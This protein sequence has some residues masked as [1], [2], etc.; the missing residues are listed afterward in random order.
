V[1]RSATAYATSEAGTE[2]PCVKFYLVCLDVAGPRPVR[3]DDRDF[4]YEEMP[5]QRVL[6]RFRPGGDPAPST[7]TTSTSSTTTTSTSSTT[8]TSTSS[9]T[10]TS[11]STTTTT[12]T[13]PFK[14]PTEGIGLFP[15]DEATTDPR[16]KNKKRK[17]KRRDPKDA[18]DAAT[19]GGSA[20][21]G[22]DEDELGEE[23]IPED[24]TDGLGLFPEEPDPNAIA[25]AAAAAPK[26]D[27]LPPGIENWLRDNPDVPLRYPEVPPMLTQ[28]GEQ[29]WAV[30]LP[31]VVDGPDPRNHQCRSVK[32]WSHADKKFAEYYE[33]ADNVLDSERGRRLVF[34]N[35]KYDGTAETP[36]I[37]KVFVVYCCP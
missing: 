12:T 5:S 26:P 37:D 11:T 32:G 22:E 30:M 33:D 27:D 8:T 17:K 14:D 24:A 13:Q 25:E 3:F 19:P 23:E 20:P 10:T 7:T 1:I 34:P 28:T 18:K 2:R 9:T 6:D 29:A 16:D 21:A 36:K 31:E 15:G 35:P 4:E